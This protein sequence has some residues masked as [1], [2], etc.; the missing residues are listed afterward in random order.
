LGAAL[1]EKMLKL[2]KEKYGKAWTIFQKNLEQKH[3]MV[4]VGDTARQNQLTDLGWTGHV[5]TP[6][7]DTLMVVD[8]NMAS[9]KSDPAVKRTIT[10]KVEQKENALIADLTI[11]YENTGTLNWK[12]TR[13]RTY[14]RVYVPRGST[15]LDSSGAMVDCKVTRAGKVE[16]LEELGL[17]AFA[18]FTCTEVG[19]SHELH[20][21]Y[22]LPNTLTALVDSG[23]Y[24]LLVQKQPGTPDHAL[25]VE[26]HLP[27][28]F[29]NGE[30]AVDQLTVKNQ[31]YTA[32]TNLLTD[33]SFQLQAP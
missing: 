6:R 16:T 3:V 7:G 14:T 29:V 26:L 23:E 15:L 13:Y 9:L 31:V 28:D 4:W 1:I 30:D 2:P 22:T 17:T 12:T 5:E 33:R 27:G 8:A 32:A 25:Q 20:L 19:A 24:A 21:R 10:Y 11:R 18:G